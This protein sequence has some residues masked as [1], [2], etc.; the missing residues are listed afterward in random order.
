MTGWDDLAREC[1]TWAEAGRSAT[2]WWRDDD[3]IEPTPALATLIALAPDAIA[4]AVIPSRMRP[5]LAGFLSAHPGVTALQ[6]GFAH[7]NHAQPGERKS[8]FPASRDSHAAWAELDE[9]SRILKA[10]L[11]RQALPVL[12]PPW[13]RAGDVVLAGLRALGFR[14]LT[15]YLPRRTP[16]IHGLKQVN[17]HVD[18]IDWKGSRG[19]VGEAEALGLLVGHFA[20]RRGGA[21]DADEPTGLLTHHLVHDP[22]TWRFLEKL[23]DFL[24]KQAAACLLDPA[25]V[26]GTGTASEQ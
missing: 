8:E 3:A 26:F 13:N 16:Q 25:A 1:A 17:T 9:G 15:R 4:L 21:A 22:A 10:A 23:R 6:H 14:G 2:W 11:G 18:V 24:N 7:V 20:A 12:T 19:F 5:E